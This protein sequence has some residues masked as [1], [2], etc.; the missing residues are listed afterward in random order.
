MG[1][2]DKR[3]CVQREIDKVKALR[4]KG[5][6]EVYFRNCTQDN[7]KGVMLKACLYE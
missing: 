4:N 7:D 3:Q 5:Y 1:S 2:K 6:L